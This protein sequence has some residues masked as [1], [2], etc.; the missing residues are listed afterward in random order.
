MKKRGSLI[1]V[2]ILVSVGLLA[3]CGGNSGTSGT[4]GTTGASGVP[5]I[6]ATTS[7]QALS[8]TTTE[9]NSAARE[10][11]KQESPIAEQPVLLTAVGQSADIEMVKVMLQKGGIEFSTKSLAG[12]EDLDG[13]KTL[14]VTVGGSS[15]G[16]GAAGID[17]NQELARAQEL[18]DAATSQGITVIALHIGGT[19]RRGDLS[20]TFITP[21]FQAADYAL[22][23]AEGDKDGLMS[24]MAH[25]KGIP[26]DVVPSIG[27]VLETL[28]AVFV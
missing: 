17:A 23:V 19:A 20:D 28:K 10:T 9:E 24:G 18:L 22:V 13:I 25:E 21:S 4:S 7:T 26:I 14:I 27:D 15:K 16:L 12:P 1:L 8:Q 11:V 6:S 3:A 2:V 5:D